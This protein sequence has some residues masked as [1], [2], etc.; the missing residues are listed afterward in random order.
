MKK[1]FVIFTITLFLGLT[2]CS[3]K[4]SDKEAVQLATDQYFEKALQEM[5][6]YEP[7]ATRRQLHMS[8]EG[9][10]VLSNDGVNAMVRLDLKQKDDPRIGL[11][12]KPFSVEIEVSK[13][14]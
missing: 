13:P 7:Q 8:V 1:I 11:L 2:A 3:S 6:Q 9:S 14:E 4:L 5:R 12:G 10:E